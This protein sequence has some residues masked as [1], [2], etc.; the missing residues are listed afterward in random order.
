MKK[1]FMKNGSQH[2]NKLIIL[3]L[4]IVNLTMNKH[5]VDYRVQISLLFAIVTFMVKIK[6]KTIKN[7]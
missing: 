6:L 2:K 7:L 5:R 3:A 4:L 1:K